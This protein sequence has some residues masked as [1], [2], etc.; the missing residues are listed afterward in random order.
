MEKLSI[1]DFNITKIVEFVGPTFDLNF[2]L[3]DANPDVVLEHRDWL[4]PNYVDPDSGI[5][6]L[7]YHSYLVRTSRYNILVDSCCGN[8]KERPEFPEMHKLN[9]DYLHKLQ[10]A[11]VRPEEI[12]FVMCTHLHPDHIGW[13]TQLKDGRWVPTFPNARYLFGNTEYHAWEQYNKEIAG[14]ANDPIPPAVSRTIQLSFNDSVLPII[15]ANRAVMIDEGYEV[16]DGFTVES[17]PGHAPGNFVFNLA[18]QS[19]RGMLSGDMLHHPLQLVHPNW[20]SGFC[21]DPV[22]SAQTRLKMLERIADTGTV[23]M[24]AHF[25]TPSWGVVEARGDEFR[26]ITADNQSV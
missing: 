7:S 24:P 13:N 20:S 5:L 21:A 3:P 9:T 6:I 2:L 8:D 16:E 19:A 14:T 23:L 26:L 18:S 22:V 25:P 11:G 17:A 12:D 4:V 1:G 10:T 15:E